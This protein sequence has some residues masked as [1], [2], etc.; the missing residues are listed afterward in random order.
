MTP[1]L[2]QDARPTTHNGW[3]DAAPSE[4]IGAWES[5]NNNLVLKDRYLVIAED[6]RIGWVFS[7][8][9]L[10][11]ATRSSLIRTIDSGEIPDGRVQGW[12]ESTISAGKLDVFATNMHVEEYYVAW[13]IAEIT[14]STIAYGGEEASPGELFIGQYFKNMNTPTPPPLQLFRYHRLPE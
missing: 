2:L 14:P 7:A 5:L 11:D 6:G 9:R 4:L 8:R 13:F 3:R 12:E 1:D 10:T